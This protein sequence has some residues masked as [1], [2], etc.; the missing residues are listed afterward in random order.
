MGSQDSLCSHRLTTRAEPLP[1][2]LCKTRP[3]G[4]GH[5][6]GV[7][8]RGRDLPAFRSLGP[9]AL[10]SHRSPGRGDHSS[11]CG[12]SQTEVSNLRNVF[13]LLWDGWCLHGPHPR[14]TLTVLHGPPRSGCCSLPVSLGGPTAGAS[15]ALLDSEQPAS[16]AAFRDLLGTLRSHLSCHSGLSGDW[17]RP[18][19]L[20]DFTV[21]SA[22]TRALSPAQAETARK[23]GVR[24]SGR[25]AHASLLPALPSARLTS[26]PRPRLPPPHRAPG[27]RRVSPLS[28]CLAASAFLSA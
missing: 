12:S 3:R 6:L 4:A 13:P 7:A 9:P 11:H 20:S 25:T 24:G 8:D 23:G 16:P 28:S 21:T 22:W 10:H 17:G 15:P 26:T 1:H 2:L 19:P 18:P 27:L 5:D 14:L